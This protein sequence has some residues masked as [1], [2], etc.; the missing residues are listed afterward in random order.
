M[1]GIPGANVA[2]G[3]GDCLLVFPESHRDPG[4]VV[5]PRVSHQSL[6]RS[7]SFDHNFL[8]ESIRRLERDFE[9]LVKVKSCY[10]VIK[11]DL[12]SCRDQS[13]HPN[14][15]PGSVRTD[16]AGGLEFRN[17]FEEPAQSS[18]VLQTDIFHQSAA[19]ASP[20]PFLTDGFG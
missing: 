10:P 3:Q 17:H 2:D 6:E 7:R 19:M 5:S 20:G 16:A 12:V 15:Q 8:R 18:S 14:H 4:P 9:C 1:R 11:Q 13:Q